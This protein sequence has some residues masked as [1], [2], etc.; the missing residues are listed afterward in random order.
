M[1]RWLRSTSARLRG[2][3]LHRLR[4]VVSGRAGGSNHGGTPPA[5]PGI[6]R[7]SEGVP[8]GSNRSYPANGGE[9]DKTHL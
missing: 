8:L 3:E 1:A 6:V 2:A 5:T 7:A 4:E 9:V